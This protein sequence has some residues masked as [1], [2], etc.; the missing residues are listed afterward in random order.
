MRSLRLG[1]ALLAASAALLA[2]CTDPSPD[3]TDATE[4]SAAASAVEET[5]EPTEPAEPSATPTPEAPAPPVFGTSANLPGG[6][7][8]ACVPAIG[9]QITFS[10]VLTA[11]DDIT[12]DELALEPQN[13]ATLEI[14]D[15]YV[16]PF[17]GGAGGIAV[18]DYPPADPNSARED[19][20]EYLLAGG[21][22]V[23]VGVGVTAQAETTM[24]LTLTYHGGDDV[25]RTLTAQ[26]ELTVAES[27]SPDL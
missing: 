19:L 20:G 25:E 22:T 2:G 17:A 18:G 7:A 12:L 14:L 23:V 24:S 13:D 9:G 15:Q 10:T 16:L 27:C 6:A 3:L 26:H 4:E 21:Q 8:S 1:V 11:V 5:T